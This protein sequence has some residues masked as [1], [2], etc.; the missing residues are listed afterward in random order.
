MA[1][2][3]DKHIQTCKNP[4]QTIDNCQKQQQINVVNQSF[5]HN[6]LEPIHEMGGGT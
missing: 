2:M 6:F 5:T 1:K 4:N 3:R